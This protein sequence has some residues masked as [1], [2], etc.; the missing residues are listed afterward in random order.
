MAKRKNLR[1]TRQYRKKT[2]NRRTKKRSLRGGS[3]KPLINVGSGLF[4]HMNFSNSLLPNILGNL[5]Q[6]VNY[7]LG[8]KTLFKNIHP[9][10]LNLGTK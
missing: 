7:I 4:N 3:T 6:N 1:K 5:K 8:G 2:K 9:N 10:I